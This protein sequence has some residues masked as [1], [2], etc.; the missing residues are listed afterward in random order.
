[1]TNE[2]LQEIA[3]RWLT[4]CGSCD[5]GL[6]EYGCMCQHLDRIDPRA[7]IS[8]LLQEIDRLQDVEARMKGLEK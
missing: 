1:M 7:T 8:R 3:D 6:V 5:Y 4:I 2:E